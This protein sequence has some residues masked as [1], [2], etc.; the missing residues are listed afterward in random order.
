MIRTTQSF[1]LQCEGCLTL[2]Y[3][4][5]GLP[6]FPYQE[7]LLAEAN[8]AGWDQ[9]ETATESKWLCAKCCAVIM[10]VYGP[11]EF[12]DTLVVA[13]ETEE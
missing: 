11:D 12:V 4:S 6:D 10:R 5:H 8:R 9:L 1:S 3:H 13:D 2:L 7:E